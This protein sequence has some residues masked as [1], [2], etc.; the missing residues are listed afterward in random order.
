[1]GDGTKE[2]ESGET[3]N[4]PTEDDLNGAWQWSNSDDF[5][6]IF[7]NDGTYSYIEKSAGFVSE[8]FYTVEGAGSQ[9]NVNVNY[10]TGER[11]SLMTIH[12]IDGN[13]FAGSENGH[14]WEAVRVNLEE[15]EWLLSSLKEE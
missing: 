11:G 13:H 3:S 1:M 14:R 4:T 6:M 2:T 10:T 5:Y 9:F 15:A 8:G 12:L 7:R